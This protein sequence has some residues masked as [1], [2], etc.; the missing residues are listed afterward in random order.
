LENRL[1][2]H[3][4][5]LLTAA[6]LFA[7]V[8]FLVFR[9]KRFSEGMQTILYVGLVVVGIGLLIFV[10]ELGHFLAAKLCDTKVEVFSIGFFGAI[11]GCQFKYGET[12]YKI[13][14]VPLGGY[15]KMPG[16]NPGDVSDEEAAKD[17]R[18]LSNKSVGQRMLIFS[19]GVIMNIL[20]AGVFFVIVYLHGKEERA[21]ILGLVEPGSPAFQAGIEPGSVLLEVDGRLNPT[22]EDLFM[23]SALARP[24][25][26]EIFLRWRTPSGEERQGTVIPRKLKNDTRPLIGTVQ[27]QS[28]RFPSGL[29]RDP[30]LG[31]K[32]E[33]ESAD[34]GLKGS[35]VAKAG[36][37]PGDTLV[38]VRA[39]GSKEPFEKLNVGVDLVR[40]EFKYRAVPMEFEVS[41][42]GSTS[43]VKVG[44]RLFVSPPFRMTMGPIVSRVK[45]QYVPPSARQFLEGDVIKKVEN[46]PVRDPMRLPDE[47]MDLVEKKDKLTVTVLR[48]GKEVDLKLQCAELRGRGTSNEM[49]P[50]G[51]SNSPVAIPALG[52]AYRVEPIIAEVD[53]NAPDAIQKMLG[54]TLK[55]VTFNGEG[56]AE[57]LEVGPDDYQ[58]PYLFFRWQFA[59]NRTAQV[60]VEKDGMPQIGPVTAAEVPGWYQPDRGFALFEAEKTVV[61]AD[62]VL[63]ALRLGSIETGRFIIRIYM[64][65]RSFLTGDLSVKY[66][67]GPFKM[68]EQT[69]QMAEEGILKLILF[70]AI[71]SVNLAVVN[72]LPIPV[73]DGGHVMFL[74]IE[75]IR[76]K[77]ATER[78]M[79]VANIIGLSIIAALMLFVVFLDVSKYAW[80]QKLLEVFGL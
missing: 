65:L 2:K 28:L 32:R 53:K 17:P 55:Q 24:N 8:Y 15:V 33:I 14:M 62:G 52:V 44:P 41:H 36:F 22:Y 13:G 75:K 27:A 18:L 11:P 48:D 49:R 26:T 38:G 46:K 60:K 3:I 10:H 35:P 37:E 78:M 31:K 25:K 67:S 61:V 80:V 69:Y 19:A 73:L 9:D 42:A 71:I 34:L 66:L 23:A 59:G 47:L 45:E 40:A 77:P 50:L 76:G 63:D 7:L 4:V 54:G 12:L 6:A 68:F 74:I 5:N 51:G 21:P 29:A 30:D 20:L 70:L 39:A 57:D 56:K 79:V 16:E 43:T 1:S 64:N 58:W 72:F